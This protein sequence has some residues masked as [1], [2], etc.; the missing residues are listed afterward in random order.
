MTQGEIEKLT[1]KIEGIYDR[2][3][4]SVMEDIVRLI[5]VNGFSPASADWKISR[6]QQLGSSEK[7]I[8]DYVKKALNATDAEINTIF[9]D[10]VSAQ[11]Y[12]FKRAYQVNGFQQIKFEDNAQ[13]QQLLEATKGQLK[14]SFD[15][16]GNSMGF[17][18]KNPD[19]TIQNV[20]L[21][22]FYRKTLDD[23]VIGISSGAFDYNTMVEKAI[24]TMTAS[25]LRWVDYDSG[26]HNRVPVAARRAVITGFRQVQ[27]LINEQVAKD[28]NTDSYEVSWHAGARPSHQVWQ[29]RVYTMNE[30]IFICGLGSIT[31]LCGANCYHDYSAFIPGVSE[32]TYTDEWLQEMNDEENTPKDYNG[33]A[34]TTYEA[35]QRQRILETTARKYRSDIHLLKEGGASQNQIMKKQARFNGV[36]QEYTD[37]SEKMNLPLQKDR[38][39]MDGLTAKIPPK[40]PTPINDGIGAEIARY[41]TGINYNNVTDEWLKKPF[42]Q[43]KGLVISDHFDDNGT[44]YYVDGKNVLSDHTPDEIETA[45][46]LID[47]FGG[48]IKLLPRVEFPKSVKAPDYLFNGIRIDRKGLKGDSK[49]A[50]YNA[51]HRKKDQGDTFAIDITNY[52]RG[53]ESAMDQAARLFIRDHS[54][55]VNRIILIKNNTIL[56]VYER[57]GIYKEE[58]V[59]NPK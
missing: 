29:G 46:L 23:T 39:W 43:T 6:L 34:Y 49:D 8:K 57:K 16:L 50:V 18:V 54:Y 37:F 14:K 40:K 59:R 1:K 53:D 47:S 3:E 30:L 20:P 31:G 56:K 55:F 7:K 32:R 24:N 35:L 51:V 11:W 9:D 42:G 27:A 58:A 52:K 22:E 5:K 45:Q 26:W 28:L 48:E 12:G 38:I 33:K 25:G 4:M 44:V 10:K 17:A 21:M 19:G 41:A 2:L 36:I 13:L 15:N